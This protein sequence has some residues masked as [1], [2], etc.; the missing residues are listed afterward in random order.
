MHFIYNQIQNR[1]TLYYG[2]YIICNIP[3]LDKASLI[4]I[5]TPAPLPL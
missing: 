2:L 5:P 4:D 1:D 3:Y